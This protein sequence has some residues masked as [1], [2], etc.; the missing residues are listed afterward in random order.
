MKLSTTTRGGRIARRGAKGW[1]LLRAARGRRDGHSNRRL[2]GAAGVGAVTGF[3]VSRLDRRRRHEAVDRTAA[4]ARSAAAGAAGKAEY[5]AGKAKGASHAVTPHSTPD[6]DDVT[7]ARKVETEI[8]RP[9]DAPKG[10][11]SVNVNAGIVELR[12]EVDDPTQIERLGEAAHAV[13]GVK[14]VRNLL[15]TA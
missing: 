5:A 7:L 13:A 14:D 10:A 9:A 2:A 11:V 6:L 15:H 3:L 8:F 4:A 1:I 12:G